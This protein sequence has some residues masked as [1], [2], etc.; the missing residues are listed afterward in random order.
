MTEYNMAQLE[1]GREKMDLKIDSKSEHIESKTEKR[2]RK[3][4]YKKI[5]L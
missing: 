3:C 2:L 4:S 5:I 1:K